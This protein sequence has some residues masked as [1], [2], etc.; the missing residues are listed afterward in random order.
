M[1]RPP[2]L[3]AEDSNNRMEVEES[4]LDD[5][6]CI[7]EDGDHLVGIENDDEHGEGRLK[8]AGITTPSVT[9]PVPRAQGVPDP[10]AI[11][12]GS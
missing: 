3:D 10:T 1:E 4:K 9:S 11:L 5:N 12:T 2:T 6:V 7:V 8:I